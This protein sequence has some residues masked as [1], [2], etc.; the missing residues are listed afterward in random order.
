[1][2]RDIKRLLAYSS[3]EN[4]GIILL[5]LGAAMIFIKTGMPFPGVLALAA[6]LYHT[7]NHAVFKSLLFL[8]SGSVYK[9]TGT[10]NMEEFGGLVKTMP[11]TAAA[12]LVGAL[13]ISGVPPLNGFISEWLTFQ[14]LFLGAL[15]GSGG[16]KALM[17]IYASVLALTGGLAAACFVKAFGISFLA[18]PRSSKAR[19]AK[20]VPLSMLLSS[21]FMAVAALILGLAAAPVL[22]AL[23][24]IAG[25]AA[26]IDVSAMPVTLSPVTIALP[27]ANGN[28]LSAPVIALLLTAVALAF[29]V[30]CRLFC[31]ARRVTTGPTWGCGYYALDSRTEYTATAFSKPFRIAF[32]FFL[33]PYRKTEQIKES[34]YHVKTM[35]YE[36]H[37]TPV[38]RRYV[39][40]SALQ[41]V[42]SSAK[43]LRRLQTGSL[44]I[45]IAYIFVTLVLL[46]LFL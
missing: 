12:F 31:G 24:R 42:L 15:S 4:M 41:L 8:A 2:E 9:A 27:Q 45:Y 19:T 39:Y 7:L 18:M 23:V 29:G 6:A 30:C 3:V 21:G 34:H 11:W 28:S 37:T 44:H 5:G 20:E 26:G 33:Q 22:K 13:A 40:G 16:A 25:Q 36:V 1:M 38:I 10:R 35:R 43:R 46:I 14:A 17:A 32:S